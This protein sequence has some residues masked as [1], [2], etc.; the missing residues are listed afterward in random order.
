MEEAPLIIVKKGTHAD[1][2]GS[3][4]QVVPQNSNTTQSNFNQQ[5]G[6]N[7]GIT[8]SDDNTRFKLRAIQ[9]ISNKFGTGSYSR[10]LNNINTDTLNEDLKSN[11]KMVS[12]SVQLPH[13][14]N[15]SN[16][17][18]PRRKNQSLVKIEEYPERNT[19]QEEVNKLSPDIIVV[20]KEK[21]K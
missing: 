5:N 16:L 9:D 20:K 7:M 4:N 12:N 1:K 6:F 18:T 21:K 15:R 14:R 11:F 19:M 10:I 13:L 3:C 17:N 8:V 2:C